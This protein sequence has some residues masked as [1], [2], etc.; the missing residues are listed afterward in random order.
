MPFTLLGRGEPDRVQTGV[1][2]AELFEVLGVTP[3]L[4]RTFRAGEDRPGAEPVLV[5]SHSYWRRRFGGDPGI[6]GQTFEMNDRVH[7][8]VGVL[9]PMPQYPD[10][11]DVYMPVSSCPFRSRERF[12][13]NREARMMHVFARLRDGVTVEQA[14]SDL[15]VV[16]D[17]LREEHPEAYA[18]PA[19]LRLDAVPLKEELT[20]PARPTLLLLLGTVGF[21]LLLVCANVAN[22]ILARLLRRN[23]EM[24]VRTALGAGRGRLLRQVLVESMLLALA[25]GALGLLLAG[26]GLDMLVAFAARFTPRAAEVGIDSGV[27]LFTLL[28]AVATGIASGLLPAALSRQEPAAALSAGGSR[29]TAGRRRA[30]SLLVVLQLALSFLLLAGAGLMLRSL[31][32]LER[33][34]PGFQPGN[35]LTATLVLNWSRYTGSSELLAFFRPLLAE[36]ESSPGVVSAALAETFPL[37]Q[38][39]PSEESVLIE[40]RPRDAADPAPPVDLRRASPRYFETIGVPLLA[41][42]AFASQDRADA[43]AVAIVNRAMARASWAEGSPLGRRISTDGG[44]TW[45]TV[46]GVV[47]DVRQHG[48]ASEV[49]PEVYVPFEQSPTLAATLLVRTA[50]DPRAFSGPLR[51]AVHAL[52]PEQ[53]VEEVRT[54][55]EVRGEA[56]ASPR[57]TAALLALFAGLALVVSA[58]GVSGVVAFSVSQ[59]TREIG[60]RMALGAR[61]ETVLGMV[62]LE[63]MALA[64]AGLALGIAGALAVSRLLSGLLY[65]VGPTDPVTYGAVSLTLLAAAAVA[66]WIP[67]Q[68][69][70]TVD[71]MVALRSQ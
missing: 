32:A 30:R 42:R 5:L 15:A 55:E 44:A 63:G 20:R 2:S 57:L 62:L 67:A 64:L 59:R 66:C 7:T 34:D 18:T 26:A 56:L 43:A 50:G 13:E 40:G 6:V 12:I 9:P 10:E 39:S 31:L 51:E 21:V 49:R 17:R 52:D 3:L 70:T 69:A 61:Q 11:N 60:L 37:N 25:G 48:L 38:E 24:A 19:G 36:V 22:L 46:V 71:P 35:V 23:Q 47:G 65:G 41:G 14:R 33:V 45:R 8:V 54:L 29:S 1:V 27:L 58:A 68:R 28:V 53:P 4:G 16:A